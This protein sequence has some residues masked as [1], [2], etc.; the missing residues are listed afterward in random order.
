MHIYLTL[1]LLYVVINVS[2]FVVVERICALLSTHAATR[3]YKR[4]W[5]QLLSTFSALVRVER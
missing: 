5:L 1:V 2:V 4:W 3:T